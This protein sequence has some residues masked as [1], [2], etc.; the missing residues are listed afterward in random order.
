MPREGG[1]PVLRGG[2]ERAHNNARLWNTGSPVKPGDDDGARIKM[3]ALGPPLSNRL[4]VQIGG[5]GGAKA[6]HPGRTS[7]LGLL[8]LLRLFRLLRLLRFLSHSILSRLNGLNA[9]PRHAWRRASL[10]TSSPANSA[11]SQADAACCHVAV[12][13]LSTAVMGFEAPFGKIPALT[14][15][16]AAPRVV[17][18]DAPT[19]RP[20]FFI[21]LKPRRGVGWSRSGSV[22]RRGCN[23]SARQRGLSLGEALG[24]AVLITGEAGQLRP[25]GSGC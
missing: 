15:R 6:R 11:D 3:R 16:R 9:T 4:V 1:H 14:R 22:K 2:S 7:L 25:G 18:N 10:T 24:R 19:R 13:T 17:L 20:C 21:N 5:P 8:G 12:I 23:L